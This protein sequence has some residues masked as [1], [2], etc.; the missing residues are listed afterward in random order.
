M[1]TVESVV[2]TRSTCSSRVS[3]AALL[4]TI[5]SNCESLLSRICETLC[6]DAT[7]GPPTVLSRHLACLSNRPGHDPV[8][9][10]C[11][12]ALLKTRLHRLSWPERAFFR[13]HEL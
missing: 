12:K 4:P 3:K 9:P 7:T 2:P 1:R 11:Q 13:H 5:R 8:G 6:W 10:S